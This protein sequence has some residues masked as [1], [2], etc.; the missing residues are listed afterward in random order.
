MEAKMKVSVKCPF[1]GYD[2]NYREA[3]SLYDRVNNC[4]FIDA[5]YLGEDKMI[6]IAIYRRTIKYPKSVSL[7]WVENQVNKALIK[8]YNTTLQ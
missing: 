8:D 2:K 5:L 6:V 3:K 4:K 7:E 1:I